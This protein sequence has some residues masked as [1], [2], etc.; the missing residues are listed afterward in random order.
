[1]ND[2]G[3]IRLARGELPCE[4]PG[5]SKPAAQLICVGRTQ[6]ERLCVDHFGPA[7]ARRVVAGTQ[8][9]EGR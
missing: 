7:L 4:Q 6:G 1:M 2:P 8:P 3:A 9:G 5:C